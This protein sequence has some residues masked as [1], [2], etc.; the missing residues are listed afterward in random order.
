MRIIVS[1]FIR[2]ILLMY[3]LVKLLWHAGLEFPPRWVCYGGEV[4]IKE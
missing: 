3:P 4:I 2:I 1:D